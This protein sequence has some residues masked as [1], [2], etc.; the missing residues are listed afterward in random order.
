[1]EPASHRQFVLLQ[2]LQ[3]G[4]APSVEMHSNNYVVMTEPHVLS[5]GRAAFL[6]APGATT[7]AVESSLRRENLI[8]VMHLL[9]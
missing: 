8:P 5:T 6:G 1:M 3:Q 9:L 2:S 7:P 4:P